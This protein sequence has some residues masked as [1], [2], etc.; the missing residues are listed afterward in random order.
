MTISV[1][2]KLVNKCIIVV[3]CAQ[4]TLHYHINVRLEVLKVTNIQIVD[5]WV[6]T[7]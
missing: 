1:Y 3:Q 4:Y 7:W 2:T 6:V 5:F